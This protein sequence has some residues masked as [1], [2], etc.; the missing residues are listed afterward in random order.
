MNSDILKVESVQELPKVYISILQD[1]LNK[2]NQII[3]GKREIMYS[4][5]IN[6]IIRNR[7]Y[8]ELY[9]HLIVWCNFNIRNGNNVVN[10]S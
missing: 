3:K 7:Y 6:L 1:L 9:D 5:I 2:L 4:D 10:I 8:G